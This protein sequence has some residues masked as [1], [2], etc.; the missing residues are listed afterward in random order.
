[1]E[2]V[3]FPRES[4]VRSMECESCFLSWVWL[5]RGLITGLH[6]NDGSGAR[7]NQ[8]VSEDHGE[9]L[10]EMDGIPVCGKFFKPWYCDD[11]H[12]IR[13]WGLETITTQW[14]MS[15]IFFVRPDELA[16][17]GERATLNK[18][19]LTTCAHLYSLCTFFFLPLALPVFTTKRTNNYNENLKSVESRCEFQLRL[20][21]S[22][23]HIKALKS[24]FT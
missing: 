12:C 10:T 11:M 4:S 17:V 23:S 21:L 2:S 16:A 9:K 20:S 1:M 6:E 15:L 3:P 7:V 22:Q 13:G 8:T 14:A 19:N 18:S 24:H 5:S